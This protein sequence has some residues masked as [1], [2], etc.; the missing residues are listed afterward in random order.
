[1]DICHEV[2]QLKEE[3]SLFFTDAN[4]TKELGCIGHL[5][6][7]FGSNGKE[8]YST[9]F[10]HM[11]EEKNDDFFKLVFDEVIN[12]CRKPGNPL[13]NKYCMREYCWDHPEN[14]LSCPDSCWGV[15]IMTKDFV[16]YLKYS[17]IINGDYNFYCYAYDK[18]MLMEK[19][20]TERG[21]P[22]FCYN[23]LPTT[24]EEIRIDFATSGYT[25]YR[26]LK[27]DRDVREINRELGVTPAQAEAMLCGST[28]G[29]NVPG[30]D[31]KSYTENGVLKPQR[32]GSVR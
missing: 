6:G 3:E 20:A 18:H 25:P 16:F 24:C 14:R 19:L 12:E 15:R 32:K 28:F 29:W 5:R 2:I 10:P 9:W 31:P 1:M 26:R 22:L 21:L 11:N 17:P 7:D 30:A 27:S 4:E 23:H 13:G 8:F